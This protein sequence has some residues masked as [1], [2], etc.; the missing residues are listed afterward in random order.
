M[1]G[2][3]DG[4]AHSKVMNG[5][6]GA[7]GGPP[8]CVRAGAPAAHLQAADGAARRLGGALPWAQ[9]HGLGNVLR[10]V[11]WT[12]VKASQQMRGFTVTV[13]PAT[14]CLRLKPRSHWPDFPPAMEQSCLMNL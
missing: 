7:S 3:A 6:E 13:T 10:T 4:E 5:L 12:I 11:V 14:V 1:G 9:L 2:L 8:G